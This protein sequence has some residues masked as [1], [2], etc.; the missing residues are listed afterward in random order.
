MDRCLAYNP[1]QD[2]H[3]Y[4]HLHQSFSPPSWVFLCNTGSGMGRIYCWWTLAYIWDTPWLTPLS[5]QSHPG[6]NCYDSQWVDAMGKRCYMCSRSRSGYVSH[7]LVYCWRVLIT[8]S[9]QDQEQ[10]RRM[11]AR[12]YVR[13][14]VRT[15]PPSVTTHVTRPSASDIKSA[16]FDPN[17]TI[18]DG[19]NV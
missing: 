14:D 5:L 19:Q 6:R 11:M 7:P 3:F 15:N 10:S 13:L 12:L 16:H 18:L 8:H 9:L 2:W 17:S 1:P 4:V